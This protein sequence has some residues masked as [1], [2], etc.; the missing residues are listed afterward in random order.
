MYYMLYVHGSEFAITRSK[1]VRIVTKHIYNFFKKTKQKRNDL[2]KN[3][4]LQIVIRK[5][6]LE[7]NVTRAITSVCRF[8]DME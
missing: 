8:L 3:N 2:Q 6:N 4:N 7:P 5:V 1:M